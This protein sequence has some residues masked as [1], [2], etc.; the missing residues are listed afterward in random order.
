MGAGHGSIA[1]LIEPGRTGILFTPGDAEALAAGLHAFTVDTPGIRRMRLEARACYLERY[2]PEANYSRLLAIY[3]K[4]MCGQQI[5][6]APVP[7][8][9]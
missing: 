9:G 6:F 7:V 5:P 8:S 2:T 1:E 3:T 4:V